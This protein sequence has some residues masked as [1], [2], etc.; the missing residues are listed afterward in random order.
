MGQG[1]LTLAL[2]IA[3]LPVLAACTPAAPPSAPLPA[4]VEAA[5]TASVSAD[6]G[7]YTAAQ[8]ER[9]RRVFDTVCSTCHGLGEFHGRMFQLTWK[10]RPIGHFFQH[11]STAMPQDRPGSLSPEE[12]ASVVAYVLQLNGYPAGSQELS[13]DVQALEALG[14]PR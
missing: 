10:T 12:Y 7:L 11:I 14:W 2:I 8:A 4:P 6:A 9:G 3:G 5:P 13:T 1:R